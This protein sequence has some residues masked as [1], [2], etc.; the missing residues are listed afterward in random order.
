M[1]EYASGDILKSETDALVNT[2]NCVGVMGRGIALQFKH[3][4][5]ENFRA[6]A[7]ACR[8]GEVQPGRMFVFETGVHRAA[9]HHQLPNQA[10]L[11]WQE[12][13]RRHRGRVGRAGGG[14]PCPAYPLDRH[15]AAGQ[16]PGWAGMGSR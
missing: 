2:V 10:P 6:Y 11:A 7:T 15:S 12:P 3:A 8:R 9:L 1:I 14:D 5:P 13:H 4:Y 16:R